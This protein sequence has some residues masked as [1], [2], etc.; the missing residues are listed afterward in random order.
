[1]GAFRARETGRNCFPR[2]SN[3][4]LIEPAWALGS[5]LVDGAR[6][7]TAAGCMRAT[8]LIEAASLPWTCRGPP[9]PLSRSCR[10]NPHGEPLRDVARGYRAGRS[11]PIMNAN[12]RS[13]GVRFR[14]DSWSLI[15]IA[16]QV[17]YR[18]PG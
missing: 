16:L 17:C 2:S 14:R 18:D 15:P 10:L 4:A 1:M 5:R 12:G 9:F 3:G 11:D 8:F 7:R 13:Q 6:K